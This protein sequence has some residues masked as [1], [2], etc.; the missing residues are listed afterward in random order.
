MIGVPKHLLEHESPRP[1]F[2][3][4]VNKNHDGLHKNYP[5]HSLRGQEAHACR[6]NAETSRNSFFS[7]APLAD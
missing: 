7:V 5:R 3:P 6:A 4:Y 1:Q 2:A